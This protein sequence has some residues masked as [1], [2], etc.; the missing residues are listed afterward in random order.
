MAL[1]RVQLGCVMLSGIEGVIE[2]KLT[3]NTECLMEKDEETEVA[4][5]CSLLAV[6]FS[7]DVGRSMFDVH[8][9]KQPGADKCSTI[10]HI[11]R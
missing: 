9:S 8:L 6:C 3:F 7:F 11:N 5:N 1:F 2:K 10:R 4:V